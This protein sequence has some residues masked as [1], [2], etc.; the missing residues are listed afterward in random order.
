M[1]N[2]EEPATLATRHRTKRKKQKKCNTEIKKNPFIMIFFK[3]LIKL[4]FISHRHR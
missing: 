3:L 4:R 1:D 2:P